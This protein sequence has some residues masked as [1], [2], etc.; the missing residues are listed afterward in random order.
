MGDKT[1]ISWTDATWNCIRGCTRVSEGCTNCYAERIAARFSDPGQPYHGLA[2]RILKTEGASKP[3]WTGEIRMVPEH[4]ADPL[5]WKKPRRIFVNSMS[6][7][8]HE[9]LT[10]EQI[11]D[12]V[13]YLRSI[14]VGNR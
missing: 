5:R 10:N 2:R 11:G 9:K 12:L 8:F 6:D 3:R 13:S 14:N 1:G 7:L 4:L